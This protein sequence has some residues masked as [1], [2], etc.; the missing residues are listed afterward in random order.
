MFYVV[1]ERHV[2]ADVACGGGSARSDPKSLSLLFAFNSCP[3]TCRRV[4]FI[5]HVPVEDR[6]KYEASASYSK[7]QKHGLQTAATD[8][9]TSEQRCCIYSTYRARQR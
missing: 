9:P 7:N 1:I 6:Q 2:W 5:M 8:V 4:I 3:K